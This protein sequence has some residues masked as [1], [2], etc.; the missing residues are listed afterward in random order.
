MYKVIVHERQPILLLHREREFLEGFEQNIRFESHFG[1][2]TLF[3][4]LRRGNTGVGGGENSEEGRKFPFHLFPFYVH[5]TN[6]IIYSLIIHFLYLLGYLSLR[7]YFPF[8][9]YLLPE[10]VPLTSMLITY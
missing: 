10:L 9:H 2:L 4:T 7:L 5:V 3:A 1:R 6:A 8:L